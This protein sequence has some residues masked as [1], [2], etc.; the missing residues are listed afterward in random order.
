MRLRAEQLCPPSGHPA[1]GYRS[2]WDSGPEGPG[3]PGAELQVA[4]LRERNANVF[5]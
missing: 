1:G 5:I 2:H 3:G 4:E